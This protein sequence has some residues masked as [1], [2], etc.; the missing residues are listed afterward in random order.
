MWTPSPRQGRLVLHLDPHT[1]QDSACVGSKD[2]EQEEAADLTYHCTATP[3]MPFTKLDPSL[4]LVSYSEYTN[5][6]ALSL[7]SCADRVNMYVSGQVSICQYFYTCQDTKFWSN[8][9]A[10]VGIVNYQ[11]CFFIYSDAI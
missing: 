10:Y 2:T 4:A 1:T 9:L 11:C 7:A 3:V 5:V 8:V 6:L